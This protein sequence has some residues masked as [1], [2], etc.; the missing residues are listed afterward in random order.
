MTRITK[1]NVGDIEVI[2]LTDGATEF[3]NELFPGTTE[4]EISDLLNQ[5]S[6]ETIETNFNAF[7]IKTGDATL[8][9]D[10]GPRDLFGDT[11][12]FL[13]DALAE[14]GTGPDDITHLFL[15]HLHPDHIAGAITPEG[16]PV[17][18]NAQVLIPETEVSFWNGSETFSDEMLG[19]WQQ[20]AQAV[21]N[22]YGGQ[23]EQLRANADIV[24]G[25]TAIDMPGHTPGHSG[26][27]VDDGNNSFAH[28]GDVVHAQSLQLAN[29]E[30]SI[31]FDVDQ[32]TA[33]NSR[34]RALDMVT[35]D[36]MTF[37][38]GHILRP[39]IG[40]LERVGSGYRIVT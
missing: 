16:A 13:G 23:T 15:T 26:F 11:C 2:S 39:S 40:K 37:S 5:D 28:V 29:P 17:F 27:R 34:K 32:D 22:A 24:S 3:G 25:V 21:L 4:A 8:L 14:A 30:I 7:L 10:A 35:T 38:G 6:K 18:T 20:L 12:G 36:D 19:Q 33:R 9:V 1:V 31:I